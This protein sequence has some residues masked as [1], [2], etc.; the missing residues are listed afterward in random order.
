[1]A[2]SAHRPPSSLTLCYWVRVSVG[3]LPERLLQSWDT[4]RS[5]TPPAKMVSIL[6]VEP[7]EA[8]SCCKR[9]LRDT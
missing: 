1:M 7:A 4:H 9:L 5:R 6:L 3:L 8:G 2:E